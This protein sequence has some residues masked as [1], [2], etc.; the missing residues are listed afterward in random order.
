MQYSA[1]KIAQIKEQVRH[2]P[3]ALAYIEE[4]EKRLENLDKLYQETIR[5]QIELRDEHINELEKQ[6]QQAQVD[7]AKK[8][9]EQ[10]VTDVVNTMHGANL[11]ELF[12]QFCELPGAS[13]YEL[14][15]YFD[16][17]G[18]IQLKP[19]DEILC[20]WDDLSEAQSAIAQAFRHDGKETNHA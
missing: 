4:L 18:A 20:S 16:K 1:E 7:Q 14:L 11:N 12:T 10:V 2:E 15:L 8:I 9:A 17:S 13:Q 5:P 6:L 3:F 19:Y